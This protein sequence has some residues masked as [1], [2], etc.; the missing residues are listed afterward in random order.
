MVYAAVDPGPI[1][2]G[3]KMRYLVSIMHILRGFLNPR[4]IN[5]PR[6]EGIVSGPSA[7]G[8]AAGEDYGSQLA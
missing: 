3:V 8:E 2:G 4:V 6:S 5:C 7:L 1:L